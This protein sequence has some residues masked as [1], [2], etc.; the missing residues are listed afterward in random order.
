MLV[1]GG[2]T[3][4]LDVVVLLVSRVAPSY[5]RVL[6]YMKKTQSASLWREVVA[7]I[8]L[9][10]FLARTISRGHKAEPSDGRKTLKHEG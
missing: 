7:D 4:A 9:V 10:S 6:L 8:L 2:P 3:H 5:P 1:V